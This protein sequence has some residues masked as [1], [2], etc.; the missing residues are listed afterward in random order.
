V[1]YCI[2]IL[3]HS[4]F[5]NG[6]YFTVLLYRIK[7]F[8]YT[9]NIM[10]DYSYKKAGVNIDLANKTKREISEYLESSNRRILNKAGAFTSLYDI[11][12]TGMRNPVIV[13]K[14]EEPGSKQVLAA[15][16]D[17][18]ESICYDMV[19]HLINDCI[20]VGATPLAVQD[21]IICG[22]L[23]KEKVIRLVNAIA[24]ACKQQGCELTGGVKHQ[25]S[26]AWLLRKFSY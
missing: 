17:R 20:V 2:S 22:K 26:R 8:Q 23:E 9:K 4:Y 19:H 1:I 12:F 13:L 16:Y 15:R 7:S 25:R 18:L 11:G 24:C 21:A 5:N 6:Y 3:N 10:R 14:T